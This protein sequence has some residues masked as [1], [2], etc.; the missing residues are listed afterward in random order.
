MRK[1]YTQKDS[2]ISTLVTELLVLDP[3]L[4]LRRSKHLPAPFVAHALQGAV[5]RLADIWPYVLPGQRHA[6]CIRMGSLLRRLQEYPPYA[7]G[8]A[9]PM[10]TKSEFGLST[11]GVM[12]QNVTEGS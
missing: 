4:V 10:G 8:Q 9:V 7:Q 5:K 12:L 11:E 6:Y 3:Y 2:I 1:H